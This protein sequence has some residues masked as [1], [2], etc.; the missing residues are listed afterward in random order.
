MIGWWI[1]VIL[2]ALAM[3]FYTWR[4]WQVRQHSRSSAPPPIN[5]L[6]ISGVLIIASFI[7]C[8]ITPAP[9]WLHVVRVTALELGLALS[10][11]ANVWIVTGKPFQFLRS[12]WTWSLSF[13]VVL[14]TIYGYI[15]RSNLGFILQPEPFA[16]TLLYYGH[17]ALH[18]LVILA[19]ELNVI[20]IF[21]QSLWQS[22]DLTY[23]VRRA[24]G[25]LGFVGASTVTTL[26]ALNLVLALLPGM[27]YRQFLNQL[28]SNVIWLVALVPISGA[29]PQPLLRRL[30]APLQRRLT[31]R[32]ARHQTLLRE[33]H[34]AFII[35]APRVQLHNAPAAEQRIELEIS[36]A[37]Q[38]MWSQRPGPPVIT[39]AHEAAYIEELLRTQTVLN[40]PGPYL[41]PPLKQRNVHRHNVALAQYLR[42]H[43][44]SIYAEVTQQQ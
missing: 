8:I 14:A 29:F 31:Q 1:S 42:C 19:L 11:A 22:Q 15:S 4:A 16:P 38:I 12:G 44:K 33:L 10:Y 43:L 3:S 34:H 20:R 7:G 27:P 18:A 35:I 26:F 21:W 2:F 5:L 36:D 9:F 23:R 6:M 32:H 41:P 28:T 24:V 17:Y 40:L 39:V 30:I 13:M 25:L 37:R